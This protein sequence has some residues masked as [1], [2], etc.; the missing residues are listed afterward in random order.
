V[1]WW[2]EEE[3]PEVPEEHRRIRVQ[4]E[5]AHSLH[6]LVAV[7]TAFRLISPATHVQ[8]NKDH[9]KT[10]YLAEKYVDRGRGNVAGAD[11]C[12]RASSEG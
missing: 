7:L 8:H 6:R 3:D 4:A 11:R 5:I 9:M 12:P 2:G 10:W 1:S